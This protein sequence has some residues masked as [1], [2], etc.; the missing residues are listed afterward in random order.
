MNT[1]WLWAIPILAVDV[2][3]GLFP[4]GILGYVVGVSMVLWANRR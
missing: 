1:V 3:T 4:R 2:L